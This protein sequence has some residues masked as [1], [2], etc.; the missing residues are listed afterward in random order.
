MKPNGRRRWRRRAK[1]LRHRGDACK[2][3]TVAK[4][5][6]RLWR[7]YAEDVA[8][9]LPL[10]PPVFS[11]RSLVGMSE[12]RKRRLFGREIDALPQDERAANPMRL[13]R[14]YRIG[15]RLRLCPGKHGCRNCTRTC[16][17]CE[18][19]FPDDTRCRGCG[20]VMTTEGPYCDGSGVIPARS[21]VNAGKALAVEPAAPID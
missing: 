17:A 8:R 11:L 4:E 20:S 19:Q 2:F 14:K 10:P 1:K 21:Q 9:I 12:T 15:E 3:Q 5:A 18:D 16:G 6:R 13:F 7:G